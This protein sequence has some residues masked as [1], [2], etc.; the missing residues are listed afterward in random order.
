MTPWYRGFTG[1]IALNQA[2]NSYQFHGAFRLK[3]P[4]VLEICE[5][6]INKWTSDY[7]V[8]LEGLMKNEE[9]DDVKEYHKDNTVS[10][11]IKAKNL[12]ASEIEK[13]FKLT[14][15]ISMNNFVLFDSKQRI[16]KY[17]DEVEIME[18]FYP[19]RLDLYKKRKEF[20]LGVLKKELKA[21]Q[22]KCRFIEGVND[23][24]IQLRNR[25][26]EQ[27]QESLKA[28]GLD[29]TKSE[30]D[31]SGSFDYLL[32]MPIYSLTKERVDDLRVKIAEKQVEISD[33][34]RLTV[35][36]IWVKELET[37]E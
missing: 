22:N 20:L 35:E 5:L 6:P 33:L 11:I 28:M 10:F 27:I 21:M 12:E 14:S 32:S 34:E 19:I 4:D 23:G 17:Q 18:E 26:K 3:G 8:F 13:R 9:I 30:D 25:T 1:M 7:K 16:K 36:D 24:T 29:C 37:F 15:S 2:T 31:Q